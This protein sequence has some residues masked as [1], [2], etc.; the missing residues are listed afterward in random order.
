[1]QDEYFSETLALAVVVAGCQGSIS[2]KG[3]AGK[4]P[5]HLFAVPTICLSTLHFGRIGSLQDV[6]N[7]YRLE[8]A[9]TGED[10]YAAVSGNYRKWNRRGI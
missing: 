5:Q 7:Y 2:P 6:V 1:M 8:M 3:G 10:V 4:S 9:A